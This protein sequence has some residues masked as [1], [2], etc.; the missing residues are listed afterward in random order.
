MLKTLTTRSTNVALTVNKVGHKE[1]KE[2]EVKTKVR[3]QESFL[4][5]FTQLVFIWLEQMSTQIPRL[6]CFLSE[7]H[8]YMEIDTFRYV[9]G[10][11]LSQLTLDQQ[12]SDV[13]E[14]EFQNLIQVN[15]SP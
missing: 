7:R 14:L 2:K 9:I 11:I 15:G 3:D 1:E 8:I 10:E 6:Y 12:F 13:Q 5:H 4:P